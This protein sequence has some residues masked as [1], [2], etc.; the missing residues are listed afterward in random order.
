MRGA[1][2][3]SATCLANC[4]ALRSVHHRIYTYN[5]MQLLHSRRDESALQVEAHYAAPGAGPTA[6]PLP[7]AQLHVQQQQVCWRFAWTE[8][9]V[10]GIL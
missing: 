8:T 7:P 5:V 10:L 2:L 3:T 4:C 1:L 9:L 6:L